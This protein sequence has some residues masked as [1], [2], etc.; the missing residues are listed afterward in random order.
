MAAKKAP[1]KTS[2]KKAVR[3]ATKAALK[4]PAKEVR[5]ETPKASRP[6]PKW[7][8]D[9][10]V[11]TLRKP[12]ILIPLA[13]LLAVLVVYLLKSWFVVALVNGQFISR[14]AFESAMEKQ[15]GKQILSNLV[16]EKLI[17]QEAARKGVTV[18]QSEINDQEKKIDQQLAGQGQT[19]DQALQV[20]GMTKQDL[21][22]QLRL[23][24]L[25]Q[26]LLTNQTKVSDAEVQDYIDKNKD[27]LPTGQSD[28]QLRVSVRQQLEQQKLSTAEQTLI[29]KL[30]QQ[31][32]ITYFINL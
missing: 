31:A 19:L 28:D 9:K 14:P 3:P 4:T 13:V 26:K 22:D 15:A 20:R 16:T 27:N 1:A 8:K 29:Q 11:S 25:I 7:N 5:Q 21:E 10:V 2:P 6:A 30:Q 17:Q 12:Q 18:S 23:N 24:S 32:H